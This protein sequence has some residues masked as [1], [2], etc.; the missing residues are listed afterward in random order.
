MNL[1]SL[2]A[3]P[4][5]TALS[6]VLGTVALVRDKEHTFQDLAFSFCH[7]DMTFKLR[8]LGAGTNTSIYR[9]ISLVQEGA[10]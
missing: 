8:L 3:S 9:I 5:L 7:V 1:I 10:L 6:M 4:H 2:L